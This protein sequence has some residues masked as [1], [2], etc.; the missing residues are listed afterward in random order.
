MRSQMD[1][2][3]VLIYSRV[4]RTETAESATDPYRAIVVSTPGELATEIV[5][6]RNLLAAVIQTEDLP[7]DLEQLLRSIRRHFPILPVLFVTDSDL[8]AEID[9]QYSH[10]SG[11]LGSEELSE[12]L[13]SRLSELATRDRRRYNRYDWPLKGS[14]LASGSP[15]T[16]DSVGS[17][18]TRAPAGTADDDASQFRIRSLSA[19]GAFLEQRDGMP[20]PGTDITLRVCFQD[21]SFTSE[22]HVLERRMASSNLPP[23]QGVQFT[24]LSDR[25]RE[26]ID[27]IVSDAL[28]TILFD[29]NAEP[30]VPSLGDDDLEMSLTP[31]FTLD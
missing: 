6:G 24:S 14:I 11:S 23:G 22:C 20:T 8:P 29:P 1:N 10:I 18:G 7:A 30:D 16:G 21:S 19:G 26:I 17:G 2:D 4:M 9:G 12:T 31:E 28:M 3:A 25:G 13:R 15:G 27:R 5:A